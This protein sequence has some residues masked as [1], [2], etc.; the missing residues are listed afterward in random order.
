MADPLRDAWTAHDIPLLNR[1]IQAGHVTRSAAQSQYSASAG[2][3]DQ[4]V[5]DGVVFVDDTLSNP[6][7]KSHRD[8]K[9]HDHHTPAPAPAPA[10]APSP[11]PAPAPAPAVA[12][13]SQKT[14]LWGA[15]AV[16]AV[17]L[18]T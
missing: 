6:A 18:L 10:A 2:F 5:S 7:P 17:L 16:G 14:L 13:L 4:L 11:A 9:T 8:P 1:L 12:G 15:A 3:L